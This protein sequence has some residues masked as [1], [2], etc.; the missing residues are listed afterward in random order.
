[1]DRR[2]HIHRS[3][4]KDLKAR[5]HP[6]RHA[7]EPDIISPEAL[8]SDWGP[9][10]LD[11]DLASHR[12]TTANTDLNLVLSNAFS[13]LSLASWSSSVPPI[14]VPAF[15]AVL[16]PYYTNEFLPSLL[17]PNADAR[18]LDFSYTYQLALSSATMM[19]AAMACASMTLSIKHGSPRGLDQAM[20]FYTLAVSTMRQGLANGD[21]DGSEDWLL[22]AVIALCLF[23]VWDTIL[24]FIMHVLFL[25]KLHI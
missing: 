1:V 15:D 2:N 10:G 19:N 5:D 25:Q 22:G 20:K 11:L 9:S 12:E 8:A 14:V 16:L 21:F 17:H 24:L 23:E 6:R 13:D 3:S 18:Y 4:E 7:Q